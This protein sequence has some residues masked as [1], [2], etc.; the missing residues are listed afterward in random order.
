MSSNSIN[1]ITVIAASLL[2]PLAGLVTELQS[3]PVIP[4]NEVQG[5]PREN[6]YSCAVVALSVVLLESAINRTKYRRGD[7]AR[8]DPVN[9]FRSITAKPD[10]S[11]ELDEVIAVRD[12]IVHNHL[13]EHN[14]YWEQGS[15]LVDRAFQ[16]YA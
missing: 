8:S 7:G 4:A 10:L 15:I 13:W 2:E 1:I 12:A 16:F 9:Y 5:A 3:F 14:A 11:D 6:G